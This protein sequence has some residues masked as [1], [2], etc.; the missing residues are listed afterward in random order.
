[1]C[2]VRCN[3]ISRIST[4]AGWWKISL[5]T[6]SR[7][8]H[9]SRTTSGRSGKV[10]NVFDGKKLAVRGKSERAVR[11]HETF[12][13]S[14]SGQRS[15]FFQR[16]IL[17]NGLRNITNSMWSLYVHKLWHL[18]ECLRF[19][20]MDTSDYH[21][22]VEFNVTWTL[23]AQKYYQYFKGRCLRFHSGYFRL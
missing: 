1:M 22:C 18:M 23:D 19:H 17:A 16:E 3:I 9:F 15:I 21:R 13:S 8:T 10:F 6:L 20:K 14:S 11:T 5:V 4:G 7:R 12:T 2:I